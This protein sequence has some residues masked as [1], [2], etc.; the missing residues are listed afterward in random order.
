MAAAAAAAAAAVASTISGAAISADKAAKTVGMR[1]QPGSPKR[2]SERTVEMSR[3]FGSRAASAATVSA[4]AA[5]LADGAESAS[6]DGD[7]GGV[8]LLS[9]GGQERTTPPRRQ[10]SRRPPSRRATFNGGAP[11]HGANSLR[12]SWS[13]NAVGRGPM[14]SGSEVGSEAL[15][16]SW[17]RK[18]G[19]LLRSSSSMRMPMRS[20]TGHYAS[21]APASA[22]V[23][24]E[25]GPLWGSRRPSMQ[26]DPTMGPILQRLS[27]AS[28]RFAQHTGPPSES[29]T[30]SASGLALGQ[31]RT[32]S[33]PLSS[34][35]PVPASAGNLQS[36][37]DLYAGHAGV[38]TLGSPFRRP[39]DTSS[40]YSMPGGRAASAGQHPQVLWTQQRSPS[41][42]G[43][44]LGEA[45]ETT[46]GE[47]DFARASM[48][49]GPGPEAAAVSAAEVQQP[50]S[51]PAGTAAGAH[52]QA[53]HAQHAQHAHGGPG[54]RAR[55]DI[56]SAA[57]SGAWDRSL[58]GAEGGAAGSQPPGTD[59]SLRPRPDQA[60]APAEAQAHPGQ[61]QPLQADLQQG[62]GQSQGQGGQQRSP[63][64]QLAQ[65]E[66]SSLGQRMQAQAQ[67]QQQ[68][69]RQPQAAAAVGAG[70]AAA[71]G[72]ATVVVSST[73]VLAAQF[74]LPVSPGSSSAPVLESPAV[75]IALSST[76]TPEVATTAN[77]SPAAAA[78]PGRPYM[79]GLTLGSPQSAPIPM[80]EAGGRAAPSS[81]SPAMSP[82]LAD[83]SPSNHS[84]LHQNSRRR[85]SGRSGGVLSSSPSNNYYQPS[86][87]SAGRTGL[88][89]LT[90]LISPPS[91]PGRAEGSRHAAAAAAG[92]ASPLGG[93]A[94]VGG[95]GPHMAGPDAYS[96]F[97]HGGI[98]PADD[99]LGG[100]STHKLQAGD[101]G[102]HMAEAN[103]LETDGFGYEEEDGGE[104]DLGGPAMQ[105]FK[106]KLSELMGTQVFARY[107]K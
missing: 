93:R 59:E 86:P 94:E 32:V 12:P 90:D 68:G 2:S 73:N 43:Q 33:P 55:G 11:T 38:V 5:S 82:T 78:S 42:R 105:E 89:A 76:A 83:N 87:S 23:L 47:E 29:V 72:T 52:G 67:Q 51:Q 70:A 58:S 79:L 37:N 101:A 39:S 22:G 30:S 57:G 17:D 40:A 34:L 50:S 48:Q 92:G 44:A 60:Q 75:G 26:H 91:N 104:G 65:H 7:G 96:G 63:G 25:Q 106:N 97:A 8:D 31:S 66:T 46:E 36:N 9:T 27:Q 15:L 53:Q 28:A 99:P 19:A 74:E 95:A 16:T 84:R 20:F 81:S 14:M 49:A 35:R 61:A 4:V 102:D 13:G 21:A 107:H 80:H 1:S 18:Q 45:V 24:P 41:G 64:L 6:S 71:G 54:H 98:H 69:G 88:T 100:G 85:A 77:A 62:H 3:Q 56:D 103:G 10:A